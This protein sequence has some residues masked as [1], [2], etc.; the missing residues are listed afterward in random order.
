M[1]PVKKV[2]FRLAPA[3][4]KTPT[5]SSAKPAEKKNAASDADVAPRTLITEKERHN[6]IAQAAYMAA[7]RRGFQGGSPE[8][9]WFDAAA[10]V[11]ANLMKMR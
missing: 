6:L 4:T 3:A 2:S 9:D 5:P 7:S 1:Q 8:Q 10:E 11:D